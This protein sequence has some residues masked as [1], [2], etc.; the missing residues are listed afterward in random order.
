[1]RRE[2][3]PSPGKLSMGI[4][5]QSEMAKAVS[6]VELQ[7]GVSGGKSS[8]AKQL[9]NFLTAAKT[10]IAGFIDAV[11]PLVSTRVIEA[12]NPSV[13]R[14]RYDKWMDAA[15]VPAGTAFAVLVAT[16]ARTVTAVRVDGPDVLLTLATPV[17]AGEAVTVA[18]TQPGA[19]SNLRDLSGN[20][21]AT[22]TAQ[23]VTNNVA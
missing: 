9:D 16:V 12:A 11:A 2:S 4:K 15:Y 8:A 18:Y 10:A 1:M 13:I 3:L 14:V 20:L 22:Y 7:A 19:V 17:A 21:A 5:L 23:A 6:A